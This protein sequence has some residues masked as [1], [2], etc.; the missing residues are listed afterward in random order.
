MTEP[1]QTCRIHATK[2]YTIITNIQ[3]ICS[4]L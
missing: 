1:H 4:V 2:L 3:M